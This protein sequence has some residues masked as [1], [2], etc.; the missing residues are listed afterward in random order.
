MP[1]TRRRFVR[2][3]SALAAVG[4]SA[5]LAAAAT[6][7]AAEDRPLRVAVMG[8]NRGKEVAKEFAAL[9]GVTLSH[10]CD[11]DA[12]RIAAARKDLGDAAAGAKAATDVREVLADP[13]VDVLIVAAPNHWHTPAAVMALRADKHVY[14]EKPCCHT[15]AEGELLV[16]VAGE[17]GLC[18]QHGT[19]R[20]SHPDLSA[21]IDLVR[22]GSIGDVHYARAWYARDRG[23]VRL[24]ESADPPADLDYDLWQGP[25][26]RRPY[27]PGFI[28]Y[29]WHW[30][31]HWGDGELGN[32]GVHALDLA[33]WGLGIQ[34]P[35]RV[36][37]HAGRYFFDDDQQTPDTYN[38]AWSYPGGKQM[39]WEGLSCAPPAVGI[40]HDG[41][42]VTFHG[43]DGTVHLTS[44]GYVHHDGKG[45]EVAKSEGGGWGDLTRT[46]AAN[47]VAAVRADDPSQ[48]NAPADVAF[49]STLPCHLGNIAARVGRPLACDPS[50]G[51]ILGDDA[52]MT[53]W[54]REY[55][56]EF[57]PFA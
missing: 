5:P 53:L 30:F 9:D 4:L 21:A 17:T 42:G 7:S 39:F 18:V 46:H 38:V 22:G 52:A 57:D 51:R 24:G 13:D 27:R 31:W 54:T 26:P 16:E 34:F 45:V 25:A 14:V 41:F 10:L 8:L 32:N 47:F 43:T 50:T 3:S 37:C 48:L 28:H 36:T 33:R 56:P 44:M 20:R 40:M 35:E 12:S 19:Q 2:S 29:D 49:A 23:A 6:S 11:V 55:A 1:L 15:P